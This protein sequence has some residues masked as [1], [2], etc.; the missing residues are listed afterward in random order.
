MKLIKSLLIVMFV[1]GMS[2]G[3]FANDRSKCLKACDSQS[4]SKS[5]PSICAKEKQDCRNKC[6]R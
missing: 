1:L 2:G 5:S 3:V 4:C 6:P